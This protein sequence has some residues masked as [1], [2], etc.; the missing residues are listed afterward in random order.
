LKTPYADGLFT[1][2][3]I[4]LRNTREIAIA[5]NILIATPINK[6]MANPLTIN[7]L[8]VDPNHASIIQAI[9]VV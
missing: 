8:M 5:E 2:R 6:V 3:T 7:A 4:K 9:K 1:S